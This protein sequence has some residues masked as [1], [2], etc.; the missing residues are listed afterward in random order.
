MRIVADEEVGLKIRPVGE[1]PAWVVPRSKAWL[2]LVMPVEEDSTGFYLSVRRAFELLANDDP[3][4]PTC[5]IFYTDRPVQRQVVLEKINLWIVNRFLIAGSFPL[6]AQHR[7]RGQDLVLQKQARFLG[8]KRIAE[9]VVGLAADPKWTPDTPADFWERD[10]DA[11]PDAVL[12]DDNV[13]P[14]HLYLQRWHLMWL[15]GNSPG[16]SSVSS[17]T[18]AES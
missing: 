4:D 8:W 11:E 6:R 5:F 10:P 3:H 12:H 18:T 15:R 17:L 13:V 7:M 1:R 14:I 9:R 16:R 2:D